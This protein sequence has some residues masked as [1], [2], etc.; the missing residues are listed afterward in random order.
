M[1]IRKDKSYTTSPVCL[2]FS[3]PLTERIRIAANL[4]VT[5]YQ[6]ALNKILF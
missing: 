4:H 6:V 3:S 1:N 5:P 2:P